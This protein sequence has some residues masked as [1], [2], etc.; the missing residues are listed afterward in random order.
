MSSSRYFQLLL[1]GALVL[2]EQL[3]LGFAP[4]AVRSRAV[5]TRSSPR[6]GLFRRNADQEPEEDEDAKGGPL[7][8][9]S[10]LLKR[11]DEIAE[12][13][14][15]SQA[16][17]EADASEPPVEEQ[18]GEEKDAEGTTKEETEEHVKKLEENEMKQSPEFAVLSSEVDEV[19]QPPKSITP[20]ERVQSLRAQAEKARLEA[21]LLQTQ[22]TLGK[23]KRLEE[24][25]ET[26][27][28]K[29]E[30][31]DELQE[32]LLMLQ[33]KL[34]PGLATSESK[35]TPEAAVKAPDS[36][37]PR[38]LTL[39]KDTTP[40]V[41]VSSTSLPF[42]QAKFDEYLKE[43][44]GSTTVMKFLMAQE[45]GFSVSDDVKAINATEVAVRYEQM[46]RFDF[47]AWP[48]IAVPSFTEKEITDKMASTWFAL[49]KVTLRD[50]VKEAM[51]EREIALKVLERDYVKKSLEDR[52]ASKLQESS[53]E[54]VVENLRDW[55][56]K[57][58]NASDSV[59]RTTFPNCVNKE[60]QTP[61]EVE[62]QQFYAE[63]VPKT[64]FRATG[65][66]QQVW[67]GY[68]IPGDSKKGGDEVIQ[69][70]DKE[71][72]RYPGLQKKLTVAYTQDYTR[73]VVPVP[74]ALYVMGPDVA[75]E[76]R[77]LLLTG[78]SALGVA[79]MWYTSIYPLLLNPELLKR[80]EEQVDLANANM[81]SDLSWLGELSFP[82]FS[83]FF[84]LQL[85]HELGHRIV[86]AIYNV[87]ALLCIRRLVSW[88]TCVCRLI[89]RFQRLFL[90]W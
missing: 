13:E 68:I 31:I 24:Q 19:P 20:N 73:V 59:L 11:K 66:P 4:S 65:K 6:V 17:P 55:F 33:S 36:P 90:R 21:E 58:E 47:S 50:D 49:E 23:I 85:T 72:A 62:V 16:L 10:N 71:L 44:E 34:N 61:S 30:S 82:I 81:Q 57:D 37:A 39:N 1:L 84:A 88:L 35:A 26:K 28:A 52:Y 80:A 42:S 43:F 70:I 48:D 74:N 8:F 32:E 76:P 54:A 75:R 9:F 69:S 5:V 67:G 79:T 63:V 22:L 3:V 18:T 89:S 46:T 56:P 51:S 14:V 86:G 27:L 87:S 38:E 45:M 25:V 60:G 77:P 53:S 7:P 12:Y 41:E 40:I 64:S 83:T 15:E 78:V 29:G 2:K